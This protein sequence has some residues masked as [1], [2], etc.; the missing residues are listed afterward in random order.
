MQ[1]LY[2]ELRIFSQ[3]CDEVATPFAYKASKMA[4][5]G[6]WLGLLSMQIRPQDY[7]CPRTYF[8]DAQVKAFWSKIED[9]TVD[10]ID[11]VAAAEANFWKYEVQ[12]YQT[13]ERLSPLLVDASHYGEGV[14]QLIVAWRK[15]LRSLLGKPPVKAAIP[16]KFGPGSTYANR[17]DAILLMD[18]LS[19]NYTRT[20][21]LASW[22]H[23]WDQTAWSRYAACGLTQAHDL[24]EYVDE[25]IHHQG[26][27]FSE[28]GG[29]ATR[30]FSIVRG[31][32][33]TSVPKN[34][35]TDRGI[36]VEPSLNL[37]FQ[38]GL[39]SII[40]D[41]LGQKY[42]WSKEETPAWHKTLARLGSLTGQ[43]ATI[44]LSGASDCLAY[45]LVR[46]LC[47]QKWFEL[48]S[49]TRSPY[50]LIGGKWVRLE[51]FSSMGNGYTF[52]LE[53]AIFLSLVHVLKGLQGVE[54]D[55][56]TPGLAISVFGDDIICPTSLAEL[57]IKSLNFV[58]FT[59]NDEKT[60][61]SG[62]FRES[63][64]A[65]CWTGYD[66]RPS[67]IKHLLS[68]PEKAISARNSLWRFVNRSNNLRG[69]PITRRVVDL[70]EDVL[71]AAIRQLRGPEVLG[72]LVLN[73][74]NKDS[75]NYVT[76][77]SQRWFRVW[78]PVPNTRQGW[79]NWRPG[80]IHATAL[81]GGSSGAEPFV[82]T[83]LNGLPV[84]AK[85][86]KYVPR[87]RGS[88]VSGY[89]FGRVAYS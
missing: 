20:N 35:K 33:F 16:G 43:T 31:N 88:Y 59:E 51:K 32:R 78:R 40:A 3:L 87:L 83:A 54:E 71:P 73:E 63:C 38:L 12:C 86:P 39:G 89:R 66:V 56:M 34:W 81:Y 62:P 18:K 46:L 53:T 48:L 36:C 58:G 30:D 10:G 21:Q 65:D 80:V 75:W 23:A 60:F 69:V 14:K 6:E 4:Q 1:N 29:F 15:E 9:F 8:Q 70:C 74:L 49:Q 55:S 17:S 82:A 44:D 27:F 68:S 61:I 28:Y 24:D 85:E 42:G 52:E 84:F 2:E 79:D 64:G 72:D 13:N 26:E 7:T 25:S 50:T 37:Y 5:R 19:E 47:P 67:Y 45:N 76:R 77:N 22:M 57:V 41:R 11:R